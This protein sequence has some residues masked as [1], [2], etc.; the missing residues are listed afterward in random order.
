[1]ELLLVIFIMSL[2]YF[3]GFEGIDKA[4]RKEERITPLTLKKQI[5]H[6]TLY[7]GEGTLMCIDKCHTCY[8]RKDITN[9]FEEIKNPLGLGDLHVYALN[10]RDD[11]YEEEY[12]R[13]QDHKI[14]LLMHFYKNGS[15]TPLILENEKGIYF[16]PSFFGTPQKVVS[17]EDAKTLWLSN[18]DDLKDRGNYY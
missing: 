10:P 3:L 11:L 7:Q 15:S 4:E 9:P 14:C 1:M 13:Y 6:S 17:L 12:G 2:V 8:L 18:N 16:L 5:I